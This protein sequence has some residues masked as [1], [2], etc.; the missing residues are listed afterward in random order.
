MI[1]IHI[2]TK[3]KFIPFIHLDKF[4]YPAEPGMDVSGEVV[5]IH[6][7]HK[8]FTVQYRVNGVDF[9]EFFKFCDIGKAVKVCG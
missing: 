5:Y 1:R 3:V 8:M 9:R 2:G 6:R 4:G 7:F